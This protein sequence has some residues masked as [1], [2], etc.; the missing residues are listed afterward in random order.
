MCFAI[1]A[2]TIRSVT[3]G[4]ILIASILAEPCPAAQQDVTAPGGVAVGRDIKNS[5]ITI[6]IPPENLPGIIEAATKDW[7]DRTEQQNQTIDVLKKDLGVSEN[8]LKA[9]FATLGENQVPADRVTEKLLEIAGHYK[10]ALA[11]SA[12]APYDGPE[13]AKVKRAAKDALE[14]GQLDRADELLDEL[15]KL[16][17]AAI[18]ARQLEC[19][20]TAAQRGQLAMSR[21]RYGDAAQDF[22]GAAKRVPE[23]HSDI[24]LVY[25]DQEANARYRQGD[26]RGDNAALRAAL[27]RYRALLVLRPREEVPLDWAMTQN[28]LG[29]VL[30]RLGEREHGTARIEEAVTVYRAALEEWTRERAPLDWAMAQNN[31]GNAL[32]A[33]GARETGTARLEEAITA[34]RAALEERTRER[35]P[36]D[37]A[38][39]QSNLGNALAMLGEREDGTARLEEAIAAYRLALEERTRERGLRKWAMTEMS[40]GTALETLGERENGTARLE[41]AVKAYRAALDGLTRE[42]VPLDWG[43]VQ[44]N[45]GNALEALGERESG[46]ARLEEA[47]ATYRAALGERT[48]ER[49]PFDWAVTQN[50]LGTALQALGERESGTA[51]L[52]ALKG[53]VAAWEACLTVTASTWPPEWVQFVRTRRDETQSKVAQWLAK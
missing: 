38:M 15:E 50:A 7:R 28:N 9:F 39:T 5:A 26:E 11:Q 16:Q 18:A 41:E 22:A 1:T 51:R 29:I 32:K 27:D 20:A 42:R 23:E 52:E 10:E 13:I 47:V 6:G 2:R 40:L 17:D 48:R 46:T 4:S 45:L 49:V 25:L 3:F 14:A 8:A 53:A 24:R 19:A 30:A 12:P 21:L 37:W 31:L 43:M 44:H 36:L 34:Y 33:I 35:V